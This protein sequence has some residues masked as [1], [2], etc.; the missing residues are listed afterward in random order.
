MVDSKYSSDPV[1]K[2][3]DNFWWFWDETWNYKYGP[4][5][6][7]EFAREELREYTRSL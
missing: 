5:S 2:D 3:E 4:Y 7:E 1:F 6:Q